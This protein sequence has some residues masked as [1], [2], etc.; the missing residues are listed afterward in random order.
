MKSKGGLTKKNREN[1]IATSETRTLNS[2]QFLQA[3]QSFFSAKNG[4]S[5]EIAELTQELSAKVNKLNQLKATGKTPKIQQNL[6][7]SID[8]L[9]AKIKE[10]GGR[11]EELANGCY[12][13]SPPETHTIRIVR[14]SDHEQE[15]EADTSPSLTN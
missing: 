9:I 3:E 5:N 11:V 7:I 12:W 13:V 1:R 14:Q 2:Q 4:F 10:Q 8:N 6:R 15:T